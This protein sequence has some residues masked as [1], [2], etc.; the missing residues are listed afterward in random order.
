MPLPSLSGSRKIHPDMARL[1][2]GNPYDWLIRHARQRPDDLA[3]VD[4]QGPTASQHLSWGAL[5]SRVDRIRGGLLQAGT[6]TG[7]RVVLV[8][9][10]GSNFIAGFLA[11]IGIGAIPVPGPVAT[12][13]RTD[14]FHQRIH[15]I[16][17][18]S[19]PLILVTS[20]SWVSQIRQ[21]T[22]GSASNCRV[23]GIGELSH[24]GLPRRRRSV[25]EDSGIAFLQF[26]SGSTRRPRGAIVSY[27]ALRA[28]CRQAA[29][30]YDECQADVAVTWVPL[31]H[32]MGL[33]TGV[34]RPLYMGYTTVLLKP[35]E[36]IKS[37]VKWLTAISDYSGTLSSAPNFAYEL[38]V[39]KVPQE[40]ARILNLSSWRVA[41]NAGEVVHASTIHRFARHFADAGFRHEAM[42]PSYG[43]AE[44]TLTVATCS[45]KVSPLYLS[46]QR[47][48]LEK[49]VIVPVHR[50]S[51]KSQYQS[52]VSSGTA[53]PGTEIRIGADG[54]D[55]HVG[56][57]A[58]RGPQLFSG[59]WT[60][61]RTQPVPTSKW[62][63]T[64]DLGFSWDG[65]LFVLG[66]IDDT[67]IVNGRSY[68]ADDIAAACSGIAGIRPGR[69]AA[70][71]ESGDPSAGPRVR[72]VCEMAS[73]TGQSPRALALLANDL[74]RVVAR[75]VELYISEVD[76]VAP[77]EL[78]VTT[79]GKV[80]VSEVRRRCAEGAFDFL[81]KDSHR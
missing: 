47:A 28:N 39:R 29:E 38:C 24:A 19:R 7:D 65:H 10:N 74:R 55:G 79:S 52:V 77:R 1:V 5:G 72:L 12:V 4:W 16:L 44:A 6:G 42:C 49:G 41:R 23:I 15:S 30:S 56:E 37:P 53:L 66:R 76:F 57:V 51:A 69:L 62:Y 35:D 26:T 58:I 22:S 54:R 46:V 18:T 80:R 31:Y 67:L 17:D 75:Q 14:A 73:S 25:T 70:F 13:S 21:V 2:G 81:P 78:P 50:P 60:A 32:D 9:P 63:H 40:S 59:Y 68:Y 11:C 27:G 61:E 34:M 45:P 64:G 8:L 48:G 3:I 20:D 33:M 43:L 36:F 71:A